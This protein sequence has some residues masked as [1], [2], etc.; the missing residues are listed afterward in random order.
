MNSTF[1]HKNS[2]KKKVEAQVLQRTFENTEIECVF[3]MM[4]GISEFTGLESTIDYIFKNITNTVGNSNLIL[5]YQIDDTYFY[6]DDLG[7]KKTISKIDDPIVIEVLDNNKP[8]EIHTSKTKT[9]ETFLWAFPL[10]I[11]SNTIGVFIM[12]DILAEFKNLF[13]LFPLFF[14]HVALILKNE[15]IADTELKRA[16][17]QLQKEIGLRKQAEEE[18][19]EHLNIEQELREKEEQFR[20]I[21]EHSIDTISVYDLNL[22][23]KYV[24]PSIIKLRGYTVEETMTQTLSHMLTPESYQKI[25]ALFAEHLQLGNIDTNTPFRSVMIELEEYHKDGSIIEVE[26]TLRFLRN[27]KMEPT[28]ILVVSRDITERKQAEK[29]LHQSEE[30]LATFFRISPLPLTLAKAEGGVFLEANEAFLKVTGLER[31]QVIGH[32]G[33]ELQLWYNINQRDRLVKELHDKR[34]VKEMSATF[35][36][37]NRLTEQLLWASLVDIHDVTYLFMITMDITELKRAEKELLESEARYHRIINATH[38]GVWMLGPDNST[39]SANARITDMLGYSKDEMLG[40]SVIDFMFEEDIPEHLKQMEERRRGL[41]NTYERR[42]RR[43]DG[44]VLWTQTI[45]VPI[46]DDQH[47]FQ[48]AFGM[49]TDITE[50]KKFEKE[51]IIAKEKAEENEERLRL[52]FENAPIGI[53]HFNNNGKILSCNDKFVEIIGSS[54]KALIGLDM[55]LLP[56]KKIVDALQQALAGNLSRYEDDYHSVTANKVTPVQ[57]VF[58]PIFLERTDVI[59]GIGIIEDVTI[60]KYNERLIKE[61]N[62]EIEVQNED[63][64]QI[65]ND[66]LVAK[67]KAEE[68]DRL[69]SEFLANMSHEIR[70]PM[71]AILGFSEVLFNKVENEE[72]KQMLQY[73]LTGGNILLSLIND[74]LDLSKIESGIL[75]LY[76]QKVD[77]KSLVQEIIQ[78]LSQK[79]SQKNIQLIT[80][81]PEILPHCIVDEI[82]IRQIILNLV[83][84]AIKFTDIGFVQ[85]SVEFI[86]QTTTEGKLIF[87]VKDTGKGIPASQHNIIFEAFRQQDGQ[88]NRKYEGTGLGLAITKRV[89]EKMNGIIELESEQGEGAMFRIILEPIEYISIKTTDSES[90]EHLPPI[91][92]N[93][94]QILIVDDVKTNIKAIESLIDSPELSYLEAENG[95]IALE[96]LNHHKPDV[97]LMDLRMPIMDGYEV[98]RHIRNNVLIKDIP[99]IAVTASVFSSKKIEETNL[100]NSIIFKPVNKQMLYNELKKYISYTINNEKDNIL[101]ETTVMTPDE[102]RNLPELIFILKNVHLKEWE[103]LVNKLVIFKIEE[104]IAN[105][106]LTEKETNNQL[107]N[108]YIDEMRHLIDIWDLVK[109]R[110]TIKN[111]PLLITSLEKLE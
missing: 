78:I 49:I 33:R 38:E 40:R 13:F 102:I 96:I 53:L 41:S 83:N 16:N 27:E 32:T 75:E 77:I 14:N 29:A 15:I 92:F 69:K 35:R 84:N 18:L 5:Y 67:N 87:M 11:G 20:I 9:S 28:G 110:K 82:R 54:K 65:N 76:Y 86:P 100:F 64:H 24:S 31:S 101:K 46:Y 10:S 43:K 99:V 91:K 37:K 97:I 44:K 23:I 104:F 7:R 79:A 51:L 98:T 95:E 66:L 25:K 12:E 105:L 2:K 26:L 4:N 85:I 45:G 93:K 58:A 21:T 56:D 59:G 80:Q 34:E 89:V 1:N 73:V 36:L 70:T 6:S 3:K 106:S 71:N 22:N 61:K 94:A 57:M 81:I 17:E 42:Y 39:T 19:L 88:S 62:D 109:L 55:R 90:G 48:G 30:R 47:Q 72:D 108:E 68:S 52:I 63:L 60:R 111:F 103:P 8:I 107:L 74:I 50:H